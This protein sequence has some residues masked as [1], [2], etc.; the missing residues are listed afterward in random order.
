MTQQTDS[1]KNPVLPLAAVMHTIMYRRQLQVFE[2]QG[3]KVR[4][5][6]VAATVFVFFYQAY[7]SPAS[8]IG[9]LSELLQLRK[10]W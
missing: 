6:Y 2:S 9:Y 1:N 8:I 5:N 3:L 10:V 4:K 7:L